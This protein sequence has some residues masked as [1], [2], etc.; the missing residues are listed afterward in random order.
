M[1]KAALL[2]SEVCSGFTTVTSNHVS[3]P[4]VQCIQLTLN[5]DNREKQDKMVADTF[6]EIKSEKKKR[7]R[8]RKFLYISIQGNLFEDL[9]EEF[10]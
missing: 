5:Q 6:D 2:T 4:C 9:I 1:S 10:K 3:F 7:F 8:R